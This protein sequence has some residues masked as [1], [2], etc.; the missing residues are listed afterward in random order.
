[1]AR[2][3]RVVLRARRG[4]EDANS[5]ARLIIE[6]GA[7]YSRLAP[8]HFAVV[9]ARLRNDKGSPSILS[10][11]LRTGRKTKASTSQSATPTW[12][13]RNRCPSGATSGALYGYG[14]ASRI[15]L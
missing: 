8:A 13:A 7:Y 11:Q 14:S 5:V 1:V 10:R 4:V 12:A 9:V 15:Q 2:M 3:S 6:L